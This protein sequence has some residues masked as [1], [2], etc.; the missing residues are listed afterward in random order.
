MTVST[1]PEWLK[2][3]TLLHDMKSLLNCTKLEGDRRW[4]FLQQ[5]KKQTDPQSDSYSLLPLFIIF[6][7]VIRDTAHFLQ[8]ASNE[9]RKIVRLPLFTSCNDPHVM[10]HHN[11]GIVSGSCGIFITFIGICYVAH[12]VSCL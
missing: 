3:T 1:T 6:E 10:F 9:I 11:A 8:Q 7:Q 12:I 5:L 2:G 4:T